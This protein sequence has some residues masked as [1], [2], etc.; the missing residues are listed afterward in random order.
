MMKSFV[1]SGGTVLSTNWE[2]VGS[3]QVKGS[4]PK[5]WYCCNY[6]RII[7]IIFTTTTITNCCRGYVTDLLLDRPFQGIGNA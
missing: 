2:D 1:E 4:P 3:R 5:V 7:Y 6:E